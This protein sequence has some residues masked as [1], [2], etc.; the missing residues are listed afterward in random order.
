MSFA[1]ALPSPSAFSLWPSP[2]PAAQSAFPTTAAPDTKRRTMQD[3]TSRQRDDELIARTQAGDAAAFDE[4]I[5]K[6]SPRLYGLVYN[7]TSNHEDTND[8]MQDVWSKAFRSIKGFRGK[9]SFYTWIHSIGVNMTINFLKK[10]GR[11]VHLSLDDVD[12]GVQNDKEF[13]ELTAGSTPVREADL[14]EL[15]IRLNEAMQKLSHDHRAVVT[16][17]DIQG[18]PHAEIAKILGIS[19]GTVRS[20]LFYA[21]RQLQNF[22]SEFL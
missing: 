8:V 3:E 2:A 20:R 21:H 9:S 6:Y 17:F 4:L 1:P 14:G 13:I 18:M 15:Q 11:R 16:M 12:A 10:R 19:E 5:V 7:M 22:L